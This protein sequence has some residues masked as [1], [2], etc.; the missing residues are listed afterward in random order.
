MGKRVRGQPNKARCP[1]CLAPIFL[2]ETAQRW[3]PVTCPE[4]HTALEV[5]QIRPF[6]LDYMDLDGEEPDA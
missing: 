2:K 6:A 3:D 4:C 5:S 1:E